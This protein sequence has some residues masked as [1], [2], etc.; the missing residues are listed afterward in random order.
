MKR[1][2]YIL[3][4]GNTKNNIKNNKIDI[5]ILHIFN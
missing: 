2:G 1:I 5:Q 3:M 4:Y